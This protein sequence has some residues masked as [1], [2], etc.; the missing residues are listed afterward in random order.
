[1]PLVSCPECSNQV[2]DAA[3]SC[4]SC[5]HPLQQ[6]P[7]TQQAPQ[8]QPAPQPEKRELFKTKKDNFVLD[9]IAAVSSLK[10]RN[11]VYLVIGLPAIIATIFAW[12][13]QGGAI[14]V[15]VT[16]VALIILAFIHVDEGRIASTGAVTEVEEDMEEI[17][18][19]YHQALKTIELVTYQGRN[20]FVDMQFSVNPERIAE[21]SK[22]SS[23][24]YLVMVGLGILTAVAGQQMQIPFLYGA[25]VAIILLGV[26]SRKASLEIRGVGGAKMELY[27]KAGDIKQ[28]IAELTKAIEK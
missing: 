8:I 16:V 11:W 24:G 12:M 5:G 25:A 20:T 27:T 9:E 13:N 14:A 26:L 4:P 6:I 21:F 10:T 18:Q 3:V 22:T 1:M 7:Q 15:A 2:S 19:R 28:V 17:S 23:Y